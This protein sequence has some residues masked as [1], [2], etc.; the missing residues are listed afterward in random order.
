MLRSLGLA[1]GG[2]PA[3][4]LSGGL[5]VPTSRMTLLRSIDTTAVPEP[6]PVR[7]LG[8]DDFAFRRGHDYGTVL[9]DMDTRRPVAMLPD[10][11]A[12]SFTT[13]LRAHPGTEIICRDPRQRLRRRRQRRRTG[14]NPGRRPLAPM[15]QPQ[16]RRL[17]PG[18]TP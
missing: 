7:V 3:A 4:R 18:V 11:T 6:G 10:R 13:W 17:P 1:L 2:R 5:G 9:I 16:R 14:S 8:V 15:A 12:E